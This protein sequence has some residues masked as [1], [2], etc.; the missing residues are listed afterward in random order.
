MTRTVVGVMGP[1]EDAGDEEIRLAFELGALIAQQ[2]WVLVTGG[3]RAGVMHAASRGARSAGGTVVG[4]L[5]GIDDTNLSP[6]V[7]IPI[8]TGMNEARNNINVLSCRLLFFVGWG[9]YSVFL[10]RVFRRFVP[11]GPIR[12]SAL[13]KSRR[14]RMGSSSQFSA[15][16][17]ISPAASRLFSRSASA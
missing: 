17:T 2:G 6:S 15:S 5:P 13:R 3:R 12:S 7:D 16:S 4:I 1:G 10:S 9:H 11:P 14:D 8:L